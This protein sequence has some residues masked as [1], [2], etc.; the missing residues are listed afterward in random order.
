MVYIVCTS[1]HC[2]SRF[3]SRLFCLFVPCNVVLVA[4]LAHLSTWSSREFCD[5]VISVHGALSVMQGSR[6]TSSHIFSLIVMKI[7]CNVCHGTIPDMGGSR[8]GDRGSGL[9]PGIL[10][11]MCLSDS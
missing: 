1:A 10:A 6:G 8:G 3:V 9:P 7:V 5:H 4:F 2:M 11:K